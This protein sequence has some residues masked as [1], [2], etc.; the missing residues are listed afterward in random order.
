MSRLPLSQFTR[1]FLDAWNDS[2]GQH[3]TNVVV[4]EKALKKIIGRMYTQD[5]LLSAAKMAGE[6]PYWST[7]SPYCL[8][9]EK[10]SRGYQDGVGD[11]LSFNKKVSYS[12][13]HTNL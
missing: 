4:M 9:H 3:Y 5:D 13:D 7:R 12:N 8:F 1:A 6:H 10:N 11:I 2:T